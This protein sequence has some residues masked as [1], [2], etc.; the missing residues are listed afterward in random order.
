MR[1]VNPQWLIDLDV[2]NIV[3]DDAAFQLLKQ[4][5]AEPVVKQEAL[6][7]LVKREQPSQGLYWCS[8]KVCIISKYHE[9]E[10]VPSAA[11]IAAFN[12]QQERER[13]AR[14]MSFTF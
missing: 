10:Y 12:E 2:V 3:A 4:E 11:W 9:A 14:G 13:V 5:Y 8:E 7:A 6:E 1:K